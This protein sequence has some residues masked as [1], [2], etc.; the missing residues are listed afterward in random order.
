LVVSVL[1]RLEMTFSHPSR[2]WE[3]R[4]IRATFRKWSLLLLEISQVLSPQTGE[5]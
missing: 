2:G 4:L 5:I 3:M 1:L